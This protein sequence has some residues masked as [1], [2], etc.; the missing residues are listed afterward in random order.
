VSDVY[1][2]QA[3]GF[4]HRRDGLGYRLYLADSEHIW[5][6][7]KR[8]QPHD[9]KRFGRRW[10]QKQ[11]LRVQMAEQSHLAFHEAAIQGDFDVFKRQMQP[12]LDAYLKVAR[13][14]LGQRISYV[15][16]KLKLRP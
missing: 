7:T 14:T 2:S 4:R 3:G 11:Q 16:K 6:P 15:L 5:R 1:H 10:R 13:P 12:L 9:G 8:V